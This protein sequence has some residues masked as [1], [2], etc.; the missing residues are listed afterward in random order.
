MTKMAALLQRSK[1]FFA[2]FRIIKD[3]TFFL[4]AGFQGKTTKTRRS[5]AF[6][7][8]PWRVGTVQIAWVRFVPAGGKQMFDISNEIGYFLKQSVRASRI[9]GRRG[10][11]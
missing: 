2:K 5:G 3:L 4:G 9:H 7:V 10:P 11:R 8:K 6:T 1:V